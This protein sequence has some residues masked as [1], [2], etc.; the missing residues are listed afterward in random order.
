MLRPVS[1][2]EALRRVPDT[3]LTVEMREMALDARSTIYGSAAGLLLV[4]H[5]GELIGAMGD[6]RATDVDELLARQD[7]EY[8]LVADSEAYRH[9]RYG[10]HFQRAIISSL[11]Q[12]WQYVPHEIAGL[13]IRP[14]EPSDLR[15]HLPHDLRE[16]LDAA[17]A[18]GPVLAGFMDGLAVSFSYAT[19]SER[20]ADLSIDTLALYERRGIGTAVAGAMVDQLVAAGKAPIWGALEGNVGSL[21]IAARLGLTRYE[22][23][24]W[25][26]EAE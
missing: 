2:E 25:V 26:H 6:V 13:T 11:A 1:R 17:E 5:T 21:R 4:H 10:R 8:E 14:L 23:E 12:P 3:P 7:G 20:M 19:L 24:L 16:E 9:L 15:D 18:A 22:G